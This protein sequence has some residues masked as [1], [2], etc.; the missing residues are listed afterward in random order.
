MRKNEREG[1]IVVCPEREKG[2][3]KVIRF[4]DTHPD[5]L[6]DDFVVGETYDAVVNNIN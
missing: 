4:R 1:H 5:N 6:T 3:S 2:I